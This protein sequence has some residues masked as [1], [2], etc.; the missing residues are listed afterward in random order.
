MADEITT[1]FN[2]P[3]APQALMAQW[4]DKP[5]AFLAEG[6][7]QLVDEALRIDW[8]LDNPGN[9]LGHGSLRC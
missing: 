7:Y 1:Q 3:E 8:L 4:R 9:S 2:L 5:P 6:K